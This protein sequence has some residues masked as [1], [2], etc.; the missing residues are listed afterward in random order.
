MWDID[1]DCFKV[2]VLT[3]RAPP[4][5]FPRSRNSLDK[6]L[7][8]RAE[9]ILIQNRKRWAE[10]GLLENIPTVVEP[11]PGLKAGRR[12]RTYPIPKPDDQKPGE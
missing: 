8:A 4:A 2:Q 5:Y 9:E 11:P 10:E 1:T 7:H 3:L 12:G 6:A